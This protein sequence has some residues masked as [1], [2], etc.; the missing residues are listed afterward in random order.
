MCVDEC[1]YE[2]I[3]F[4]PKEVARK[5]NLCLHRV[6]KGLF[7]ACADNICPGHCIYFGDPDELKRRLRKST[8][9][10]KGDPL[11]PQGSETEN[12]EYSPIPISWAI[13]GGSHARYIHPY[14]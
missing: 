3:E 1:P 12:T 14:R 5:C 6:E 10:A 11:R 8:P 9:G 13:K 4:D 2:A 7:P